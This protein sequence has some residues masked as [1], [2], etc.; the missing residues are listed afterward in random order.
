VGVDGQHLT[1]IRRLGARLEAT[2][3][4]PVRFVPLI[5]RDE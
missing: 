1:L 4:E 5:V 3:L 2:T